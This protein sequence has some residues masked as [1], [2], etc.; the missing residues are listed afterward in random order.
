MNKI[1]NGAIGSRPSDL[2]LDPFCG[3]GTT[4]CAAKALQR[5]YIGIELEKESFDIAIA[6]V[7]ATGNFVIQNNQLTMF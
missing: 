2:I 4:L 6:R 5:N 1:F 3:S 7:A